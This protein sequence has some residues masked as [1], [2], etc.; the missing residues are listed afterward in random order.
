MSYTDHTNGAFLTRAGNYNVG[1]KILD[2]EITL[3]R[4]IDCTVDNLTSGAYYKLWSVPAGFQI[5][6]AYL[7]CIATESSDTVD[8]V[9]DDSATTTILSNGA[10]ATIGTVTATTA[11]KYYASAGF[12]CMKPDAA[13]TTGK[14]YVTIKGLVLNTS[15]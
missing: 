5:N 8:I 1:E 7:T 15:M 4:Y 10:L 13:L 9:D 11:R 14:F 3:T 2:Q 6:E 12:I